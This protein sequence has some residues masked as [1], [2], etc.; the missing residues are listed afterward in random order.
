MIYFTKA[1]DTLCWN[2]IDK[3]MELFG[4]YEIFRKLVM[5][6]ISSSSFSAMVEGSLLLVFQAQKGLKQ[7]DPLSPLLF[8]LAIE[9]VE[10]R[11]LELYVKGVKIYYHS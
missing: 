6:Y 1:F 9:A 8:M 5:V 7:G 11:R 4:F 2:S 3:V 10:D